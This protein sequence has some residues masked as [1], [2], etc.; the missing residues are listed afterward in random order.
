MFTYVIVLF[1]GKIQ[2]TK[3]CEL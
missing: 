1:V 2:S 3:R